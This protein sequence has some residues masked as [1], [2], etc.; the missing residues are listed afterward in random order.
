MKK[1]YK[2]MPTDFETWPEHSKKIYYA[3]KEHAIAQDKL[4]PSINNSFWNK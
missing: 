3:Q 2:N 4:Y 1:K